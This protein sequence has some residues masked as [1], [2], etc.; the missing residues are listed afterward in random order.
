MTAGLA[1]EAGEPDQVL[2]RPDQTQVIAQQRQEAAFQVRAL[3]LLAL[4]QRD[5]LA[6]FAH[7]HHVMAEVRL[8]PLLPEIQRDLRSPDVMRDHTADHAIRHRGPHHEAVEHILTAAQAEREPAGQ[9][10]QDADEAQQRDHR[11]EQAHRQRDAVG[12]EKVQVFLDP[13]VG[14]VGHVAAARKACQLH[15]VESLP[16]QPALQVVPGHPRAPAHL[17]QLREVEPVDGDDDVA[18]RQVREAQQLGPEHSLV[19][20]LQ[21]VVEQAVPLVHQHQH[22]HGAQVE[23]HDGR[24]QGPRLPL[25]L[26]REKGRGQRPDPAQGDLGW[27]SAC[28]QSSFGWLPSEGKPS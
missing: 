7:P 10:P 16:R 14:V 4:V 15:P 23:Q 3:D 2:L 1:E 20:L 13:L 9:R 11:V 6:V 27:L 5:G 24:Q 28:Q 21:C 25:V 19:A 26:R 12:G 18:E 17:Q 8:K 22:V